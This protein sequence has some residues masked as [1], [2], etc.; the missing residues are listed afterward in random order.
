MPRDKVYHLV[1]GVLVSLV[2]WPFFPPIIGFFA[3]VFAGAG[4]E[5]RDTMGY[6]TPE[7][8]DFFATIAGGALV[9]IVRILW[10][11]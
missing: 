4:K 9:Y 1:A 7:W 11:V 5:I 8:N 6:G 10:A 2:F 3:S